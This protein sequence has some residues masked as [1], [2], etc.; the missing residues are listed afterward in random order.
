VTVLAA[1]GLVVRSL[2]NLQS[3]DLGLS[4]DRLVLLDLHMPASKF[5]ERERRA[6]FLDEAI[7]QL[8]GLPSIA[9]ATPVNVSPFADRGWDVPRITAEGQSSDEAAA[10][11]T[12][13]L[14]SIHPNY[15]ATFG[16]SL[17]R[18]RAFTLDDRQGQAAVAI[19]SEDAAARIWPDDNPIGK[20]LK[21]GAVDSRAR[22]LEV[23]GVAAQT[24]YRTVTARRPTLYVP[25]A[26]FQTTATMLVV[27][28]TAPLE[29]LTSM[30][31]ERLQ[32]V[33]Q[34]VRVMRVAPFSELLARPMARPRFTA[35]VLTVFA[36]MALLLATVGLY[37]VMS[38]YVRQ[39]DRE[40]AV[41][42]ALGATARSVRRLVL[43][44]A[45]KL[46]GLGAAIGIAG[47]L[48]TTR[49]LRGMLFE[50][51]P[52]DPVSLLAAALL[53]VAA[54]ALASYG[55]LRRAPRADLMTTLRSQ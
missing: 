32:G 28:T 36:A 24:R 46:V 33:D 2:L 9:A 39:R 14:E 54:A 1:A 22:W 21:M 11:P 25:A 19:V 50:V 48:A 17:V 30:A 38:A 55:P 5:A 49:S 15:F 51:G 27:R 7:A 53:L 18:G 45:A 47:A 29:L 37:A 31:S 41:R 13:D 35:F 16:V 8:Q 52:L 12:L 42:L 44:E 6:R 3:I 4:A 34:D 20:R 40:I 43:S 23:V 10:N 26:Q